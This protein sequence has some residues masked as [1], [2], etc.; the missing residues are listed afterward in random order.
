MMISGGAPLS[1]DTH[2]QVKV[3]LC[4][5]VV[6]GYGLTET[7]ASA[8]VTDRHDMS[9]GRC[10]APS[11]MVDVRLINW[12]EGNYRVTDKPYPRGEIVIGGESVSTGYYK[13]P[14]KTAEEFF[15]Q[16][17]RRWFKTG[18]IGEFHPDG[19]LKIIGECLFLNWISDVR[20]SSNFSKIHFFFKEQK[21]SKI[22]NQKSKI[23]SKIVILNIQY[24]L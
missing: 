9:L 24:F 2:V 5:E 12:D 23:F 4:I 18:D 15:E 11:S 17:G 1:P 7:T 16:D 20:K 13:L 14:G 3:C 6:Q 8:C 22:K 19:V 21:I 10:G